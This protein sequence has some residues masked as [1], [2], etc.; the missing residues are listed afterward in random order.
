MTPV[1]GYPSIFH[2]ML[3]D[4]FDLVDGFPAT[5]TMFGW[6]LGVK[7]QCHFFPASHVLDRKLWFFDI[8]CSKMS[9]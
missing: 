8:L 1:G 6:H 7:V 9:R 3:A 2:R 4:Y 5:R